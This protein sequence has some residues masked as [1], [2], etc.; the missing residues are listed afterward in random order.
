MEPITREELGSL[1]DA[2]TVTLI[3]ALPAAAYQAEHLPG[4]VNVPGP[5]SAERA[6]ELA[7]DPPA[8]VVVYC[9]GPAC[10]RS[11]VTAADFV[12]LGYTDVRVYDGGKADWAMAG[13][14]FAGARVGV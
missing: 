10:G 8:T 9:S 14:P 4:A 2:G 12:R 11:K 13:L 6:A 5:L 7:P 3:E 1:L